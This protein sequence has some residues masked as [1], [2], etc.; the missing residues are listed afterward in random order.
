MCLCL[1]YKSSS[2]DY[3]IS[4][5]PLVATSLQIQTSTPSSQA[6]STYG[7]P[8]QRETKLQFIIVLLYRTKDKTC[9]QVKTGKSIMSCANEQTKGTVVKQN[10]LPS[11]VPTTS[12]LTTYLF[13][14]SSRWTLKCKANHTRLL[15]CKYISVSD[16]TVS[17]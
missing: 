1:V 8:L 7:F 2:L 16:L 14:F 15:A 9:Q 4:S 3:V 12:V 10:I 11:T 13:Q 17:E 6:L 5:S